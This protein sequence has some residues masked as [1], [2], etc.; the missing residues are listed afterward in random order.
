M[1]GYAAAKEDGVNQAEIDGLEAPDAVYD[2]IVVALKKMWRKTD[3]RAWLYKESLL[4]PVL[5]AIDEDISN[6]VLTSHAYRKRYEE[7]LQELKKDKDAIETRIK[8]LEEMTIDDLDEKPFHIAWHDKS[9]SYT[10]L[11][12]RLKQLPAFKKHD[13]TPSE[14]YE[15][16]ASSLR[17]VEQ[18]SH[19]DQEEHVYAGEREDDTKIALHS[20][21]QEQLKNLM[22]DNAKL[23]REKDAI[24]N[25]FQHV[26]A[27]NDGKLSKE[28]IKAAMQN[29]ADLKSL[30]ARN[31]E[32]QRI[33][34]SLD[35]N[36]DGQV[37]EEEF[38]AA[39]LAQTV[40]MHKVDGRTVRSALT[41]DLPKTAPEVVEGHTSED[42]R[43][44][45]QASYA[46]A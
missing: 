19:Q 42:A 29:T 38:K 10:Q 26:D 18:L 9:L 44:M 40:D 14:V 7:E 32:V 17:S 6:P 45:T 37:D 39:L 20:R 28:E 27:D 1:D 4:V 15:M 24:M 46:V 3:K 16:Y 31:P 41:T 8:F 22:V 5:S 13:V 43:L 11:A 33:W 12:T 2:D 35:R 30:K 23:K 36:K 25:L 21:L 34:D